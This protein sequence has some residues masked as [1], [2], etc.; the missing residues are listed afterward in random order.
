MTIPPRSGAFE[1]SNNEL[2]QLLERMDVPTLRRND[3]G[4]L[5]RNLGIRNS[6]HPDFNRAIELIKQ[7]K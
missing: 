5:T 4:W 7:S 3:M 6:E 2:Q 1:G